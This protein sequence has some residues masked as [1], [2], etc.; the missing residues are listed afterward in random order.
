MATTSLWRISGGGEKAL[1]QVI[2]YVKNP[3]KTIED[4]SELYAEKRT[5]A[6]T[7]SQV[8]SYAGRGEAT[9]GGAFVSG[10][11]CD[12]EKAFSE[13]LAVKDRFRKTEGTIAYHGYQ[14][15]AEGEVSPEQAHRIG[16][17]LARNLWGDRYQV[18]VTTHLDKASHLHNHFVINT[19]SFVDG[20]KFYRSKKDYAAMR[21]ESDRLCRQEE[22]S[23]IER[24]K[25]KGVPYPEWRAGKEDLAG[26]VRGLIR[27]DID[28]AI[29]ESNSFS[30]FLRS[31]EGFG[32]RF[33]LY[34]MDGDLLERPSILAPGAERYM[35][36]YKLGS[37]YDL[38]S[39]LDRILGGRAMGLAYTSRETQLVSAYWRMNVRRYKRLGL[40]GLFDRYIFELKVVKKWPH[41]RRAL[42]METRAAAAR[43]A[44]YE[45]QHRLLKDNGIGSLSELQE[46]REGKQQ[47]MRQAV[48]ERQRIRMSLKDLRRGQEVE[49]A[50]EAL[51]EL[52]E[53]S[54]KIGI[55][56]R[57]LK[58][59]EE[60]AERSVK[61]A[62]EM[63]RIDEQAE[64]FERLHPEPEAEPS[65]RMSEVKNKKQK[66]SRKDYELY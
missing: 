63:H 13:M 47:E 57:Q 48:S 27:R 61:M 38:D 18:L 8:L 24:P 4:F 36:F 37:G 10:I 53:V 35:R 14:S 40:Q 2:E 43:L 65:G 42:P 5:K 19:V 54:G 58:D 7:L 28:L 23:V 6:E 16:V 17:E 31:M 3:E 52:R 1:S 9:E 44:S 29:S 22:L 62:D 45:R 51:L 39:I 64:Q 21:H 66:R 46:Y 33:K 50:K 49:G 41:I 20:K 25:A 60:I 26:S 56:R 12:P 55:I 11:N 59:V 32:Y 34:R 30:E 15:F